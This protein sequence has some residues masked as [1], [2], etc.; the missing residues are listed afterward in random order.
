MKIHPNITNKRTINNFKFLKEEFYKTH[1]NLY[2]YS[3]VIY[4]GSRDKIIIICQKHGEF[5][6]SPDNHKRGKGCGKCSKLNRINSDINKRTDSFIMKSQKIHK[7]KY[8]YSKVIYKNINTKIKI[9]CPIHGEFEQR[10]DSHLNSSGCTKCGVELSSNSRKTSVKDFISKSNQVHKNKYDYSEVIYKNTLTKVI[11]ICPIHGE[12]QQSP[13][14]HLKGKGCKVCYSEKDDKLGFKETFIKRSNKIYKNKYDY[15][16]VQ[17]KNIHKKVTIICP[18]HGEFQQSPNNHQRG[19]ECF[20]CTGKVKITLENFLEKSKVHHGDKYEYSKVKIDKKVN[21]K[22]KLTIICPVHG[23]FKQLMMSHLRGRGCEKCSFILIG[24]MNSI[25]QKEFI[26]KSNIIHN[27]EYKYDNLDYQNMKTKVSITCLKHG[28]FLQT[29]DSH[30]RGSGCPECGDES[31]SKLRSLSTEEFVSRSSIIHEKKYDYSNVKYQS[32]DEEVSILCP[33]HG[34]FFQIPDLHLRGSGCQMCSET[35]FNPDKK[36][37]FYVRLISVNQKMGFKYGI[38][39]KL[40]G[41]REK[42]QKRSM[43]R[44]DL[45]KTIYK[46]N[47]YEKG[48]HI[49]FV[50][51]I[52]KKTFG[53]KGYFNKSELEDGFSETVQVNENSILVLENLIKTEFSDDFSKIMNELIDEE[54]IKSD[55]LRGWGI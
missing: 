13:G 1:K 29:P 41:N 50:E 17:Y 47:I 40:D 36:S 15:S 44:Y 24:K 10:P 30:S 37:L 34:E 27:Y 55:G 16:K 46:S 45:F 14:N 5:K 23:E 42:Q 38:T 52:L 18:I 25:T 7:N 43:K 49:R 54:I 53:R 28:D 31:S 12:F 6:M 51:E 9:I 21:I 32:Y 48:H 3:K 2:D 22:S 8:D 4:K 11:I 33:I 19:H 39:N 35:G 20:Q 26:D